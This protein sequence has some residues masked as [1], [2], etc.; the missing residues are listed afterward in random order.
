MIANVNWLKFVCLVC[1]SISKCEIKIKH[2]QD[3]YSIIF[4]QNYKHHSPNS[5]C[6]T[7]VLEHIAMHI[8]TLS[9]PS[10]DRSYSLIVATLTLGSRPRQ[11]GLTRLQAKRKPGSHIAC[12]RECMKVWG[13]E[14]SHSQGNSHFGRWSP[15]GGFPN[16][17]RAIAG[18]QNSM[19]WGI[20]YIIGK[21]L[22]RRCLKW[23]RM[24]HLDIWHTSYGQ[25]KGRESNWH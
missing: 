23:A 8:T 9:L 11:K 12:S 5:K 24:T 15:G 16:I 1:W 17:Q 3:D 19:Y 7:M 14:P 21:L 20:P 6:Q 22:E 10:M 25:K 4:V 2:K 13:N 18:G